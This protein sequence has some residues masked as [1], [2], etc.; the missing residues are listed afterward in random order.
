M[1]LNSKVAKGILFL[2]LALA[3]YL[4]MPSQ[5]KLIGN[6]RINAQTFPKVL[7]CAMSICSTLM[8]INGLLAKEKEYWTINLAAIKGLLS[9]VGM[10]LIIFAYVFLIPRIGFL[11]SSGLCCCGAMAF[12]KCKKVG[13]YLTVAAFIA[14]VYLVFTKVL[15]VPLP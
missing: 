8:I 10:L 9:P 6:D 2:L 12:L 14:V 13:Y 1:K 3:V 11:L 7:V 4:L 15:Y 5:I